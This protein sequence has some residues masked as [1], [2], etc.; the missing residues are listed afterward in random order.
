MTAVLRPA[1]A[2]ATARCRARVVFP[3]PPYWLT[4]AMVFMGEGYT[5][6]GVQY[7]NYAGLQATAST[8]ARA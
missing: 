8:L 2:E 5:P 4:M 7:F 6:A 3:D 1:A